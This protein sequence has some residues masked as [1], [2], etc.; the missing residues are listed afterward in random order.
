MN[1]TGSLKIV[2]TNRVR[3]PLVTIW[4]FVRSDYNKILGNYI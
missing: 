1:D 4:T 2:Q 3:L